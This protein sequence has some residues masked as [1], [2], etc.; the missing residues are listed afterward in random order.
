[1]SDDVI[2]WGGA[3]EAERIRD[4][5]DAEQEEQEAKLVKWWLEGADPRKWPFR[6]P[7]APDLS[8]QAGDV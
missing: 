5:E 1:M 2:D 7:W 3:E 4:R 8:D 6:P